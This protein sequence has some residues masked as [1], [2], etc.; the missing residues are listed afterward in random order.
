M[1]HR[2]LSLAEQENVRVCLRALRARFGNWRNV[3][4]SLPLA[5]SARVETMSGRVEVGVI[6]AFRV[7]RVL[8]A[9][10]YD[11]IAGRAIPADTCKHCGKEASEHWRCAGEA[12]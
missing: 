8:E 5:H 3:E 11:V 2:D 4:R 12:G 9:S 6:V 7:A 1:P 10:I